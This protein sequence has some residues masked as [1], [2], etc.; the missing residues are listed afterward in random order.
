MRCQTCALHERL[1]PAKPHVQVIQLQTRAAGAKTLRR[2]LADAASC[3]FLHPRDCLQESHHAEKSESLLKE[4]FLKE[5]L[6]EIS[7][8]LQASARV[9]NCVEVL[10]V[11]VLCSADSCVLTLPRSGALMLL[12]SGQR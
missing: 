10:E 3:S 4:S 6:Q 11:A 5:S 8:P 7:D 9:M 12:R 2:A 1:K